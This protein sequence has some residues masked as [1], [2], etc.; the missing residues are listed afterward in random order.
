[1]NEIR[2]DSTLDSCESNIMNRPQI[3]SLK[4]N[5]NESESNLV[6]LDSLSILI[7]SELRNCKID[8]HDK[9]TALF[10]RVNFIYRRKTTLNLLSIENEKYDDTNVTKNVPFLSTFCYE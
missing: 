1:M 4:R 8:L 2:I 9:A 10:H 7:R 6:E 5:G 3:Q